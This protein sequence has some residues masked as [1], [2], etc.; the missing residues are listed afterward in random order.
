MFTCPSPDSGA[1][2][3]KNR[4]CAAIQS[5]RRSSISSYVRPMPPRLE[6]RG[7]R[8]PEVGEGRG[9]GHAPARRAL[10]EAAL[11]QVGLVD[12]LDRVRLLAHRDREGRQP[13]RAAAEARAHRGEDL[14]VEAVE[15]EGVDLEQR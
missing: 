11:E 5:R 8:E 15:A 12:V 7:R 3:T 1:V 10:E 2:P 13:D 6:E 14:A 9:G 4:G